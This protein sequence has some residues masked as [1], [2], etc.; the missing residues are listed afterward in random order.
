MRARP[1]LAEQRRDVVLDRAPGERQAVADLADRLA[2]HH[3]LDAVRAH[4]LE[5]AGDVDGAIRHYRPAAGRTTSL[6]EQAYL[7]MRAARLGRRPAYRP[8]A[9]A[10]RGTRGCRWVAVPAPPPAPGSIEAAQTHGRALD[11]RA[12]GPYIHP[13]G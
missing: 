1:S 13:N 8:P 2:G 4:L 3:R 9:A 10:R 5:M 6:A 7:R 12:A 11:P